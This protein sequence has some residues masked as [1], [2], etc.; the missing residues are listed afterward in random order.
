[1]KAAEETLKDNDK[2]KCL[3][4]TIFSIKIDMFKMDRF[5]IVYDIEDNG[6]LDIYCITTKKT[7]E[8]MENSYPIK[9]TLFNMRINKIYKE[10]ITSKAEIT[11][12]V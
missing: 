12:Y 3:I 7:E 4:G 10:N 1:M 11:L 5:Y 2:Y 8:W 6:N 9:D